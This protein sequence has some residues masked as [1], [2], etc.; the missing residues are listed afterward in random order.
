MGIVIIVFFGGGLRSIVLSYPYTTVHH[1]PT[2]LFVFRFLNG[3]SSDLLFPLS[4]R[5]S[6]FFSFAF[7]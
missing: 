6:F 5:A 1:L 7:L 3:R 2:L 4:S